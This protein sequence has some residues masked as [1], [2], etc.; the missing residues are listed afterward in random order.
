MKLNI[1]GGLFVGLIS[2]LI[3]FGLHFT[4]MLRTPD[5]AKILFLASGVHAA[6]IILVLSRH[7][8]NALPEAVPFPKLF[9]AGLF[10]SFVAGLC[11]ALGMFVFTTQVDKTH[12]AWVVEQSIEQAKTMELPPAELEAHIAA[13][14]ELVTPWSLSFQSLAG[15]CIVGFFLS[16]VIGALLR[17]RAVQLVNS[18]KVAQP[19]G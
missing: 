11:T 5:G 8:S 2:N 9:G 10:L 12:T 18:E 15:V 4:G 13:L 19:P 3:F 7:R 14:P 1:L 16:L 17:L 6:I